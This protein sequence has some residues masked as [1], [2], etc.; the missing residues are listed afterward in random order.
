MACAGGEAVLAPGEEGARSCVW[1][2]AQGHKQRNNE[3]SLCLRAFAFTALS[4]LVAPDVSLAV[5]CPG[6]SEIGLVS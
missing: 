2:V 5:V 1:E 3:Q 4:G 6:P